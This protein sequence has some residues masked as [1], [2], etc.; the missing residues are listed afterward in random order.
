MPQAFAG[1]L[2]SVVGATGAYATA[3]Y[4][5]G[6]VVATYAISRAVQSIS[7]PSGIGAVMGAARV[8]VGAVAGGAALATSI[9]ASDAPRRVIYGTVK[10]GGVPVYITQTDTGRYVDMAIYVAEGPITGVSS[11][12]WIGDDLS[13]ESKFAGL[14]DVVPFLGAPGQ[15]H[16]ANL[17]A[18]S[19]GEWTSAMV[20]TGCAWVNVRYE[21]ESQAFNRGLILPAFMVTGCPLYDPRTGLTNGRVDNPA[22]VLLHFIRSRW[23]FQTTL[24]DSD[25]D[26]DS[27]AA[28]ANVCDEIVVSVNAANV[29]NGVAGRVRRYSF[30]GVFEATGNPSQFVDAVCQ[31]MAGNLINDGVNVRCYAGAYRAPTGPTLSAEYLRAAPAFRTHPGGQQRYNIARGTY[32]EPL[33]NWEMTD[34]HEQRLSAGIIAADGEIVSP[35]DLPGVINGA[36][37]QRLARLQMMVSRSAVPLVLRCNYAAFQWQL[38]DTVTVN[39]PEVGA[40]GV[41]L[42]VQYDWASVDDGGGIDMTLIPHLASD[43]TWD[44]A[45]M[46]QTVAPIQVPTFRSLPASISG[47]TLTGSEN[48]ADTDQVVRKLRGAWTSTDWVMLSHYEIKFGK[49][50]GEIKTY[51]TSDKFLEVENA[52]KDTDYQIQVRA[53][54]VDGREGGWSGI[55]T[56]KVE[57]DTTGPGPASA[58]SVTGQYTHE[59]RWT[60]PGDPDIRWVHV[61]T[62]SGPA[63]GS[64]T[65]IYENDASPNRSMSANFGRPAGT[66]YAVQL[67]DRSGNLGVRVYAGVGATDT[68]TYIE[69]I[70]TSVDELGERVTI[71]EQG[72]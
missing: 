64:P 22:L 7:K 26:F 1:W 47:L 39:L 61:L 31:A 57:P 11:T 45:T 27:F 9:P 25:I 43:Y 66:H 65:K 4:A 14:V 10:A 3:V 56:G 72:G 52:P 12:I 67:E 13:N 46:E 29:V 28:A 16:S 20:G 5:V 48:Y 44:P 55:A 60:N 63:L 30:T 21:F 51:Q 71:I 42:I 23:A 53:V 54:G 69:E 34:Y 49:V 33:Q 70:T 62:V 68:G 37:A 59:V 6:Y 50:G 18:V 35:L 15:T 41:F 38:Y 36:Q 17:A 40:V 32:R 24:Q 2:V 8:S 19:R 58:L